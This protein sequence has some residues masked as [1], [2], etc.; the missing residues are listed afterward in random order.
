LLNKINKTEWW[1]GSWGDKSDRPL[2]GEQGKQYIN[3]YE[4][5]PWE[6]VPGGKFKNRTLGGG[7]VHL[8]CG[9]K[10]MELG[11]KNVGKA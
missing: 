5:G 7:R 11:G 4:G 9:G 8:T 2:G 6:K 10:T 1:G 3:C